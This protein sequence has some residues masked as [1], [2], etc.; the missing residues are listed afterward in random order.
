MP[1]DRNG[2]ALIP[3]RTTMLCPERSR[4]TGWDRLLRT[5]AAAGAG[6]MVATLLGCAV[7]LVS[8]YDEQ[9][10]TGL[11]ELNTDVTAFVNRMIDAAG[12]PAG[13]YASNKTFY[14]DE[15]AKLDTLLARAQA[16]KV[17]NRCPTSD[18]MAAAIKAAFPAPS[19]QPGSFPLPLPDGSAVLAQVSSDACSVVLLQLVRQGLGQMKAFHMAQGP[20]GIPPEAHDPLLVGGIGSLIHA[21]ITVELAKKS[22]GSA[23]GKGGS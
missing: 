21:A 16:N 15:D 1:L 3:T 19:S 2:V 8:G 11:S 18:V 20:K 5:V 4:P 6:A 13:E 23:G 12:T 7:Q 9:I 22:G 17:L 14:G 10:D